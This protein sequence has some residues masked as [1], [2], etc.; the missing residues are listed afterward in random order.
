MCVQGLGTDEETVMEILSTRSRKQLDDIS[1]AYRFC[2]CPLSDV[3]LKSVFQCEQFLLHLLLFSVQEGSGEGTERR[4]QR[5]LCQACG[6]TAS[7]NDFIV[8]LPLI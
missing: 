1:A 7:C 3:K 2:E 5:R 4:N 6:G 8:T